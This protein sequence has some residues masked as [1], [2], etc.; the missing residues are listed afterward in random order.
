VN[1]AARHRPTRV[2]ARASLL[3]VTLSSAT[4]HAEGDTR[5]A[6]TTPPPAGDPSPAAPPPAASRAP[7][8]P[9]PA[10]PNTTW[11][12]DTLGD[13]LALV[14]VGS[15]AVGGAF[16]AAASA[17][18]TS[19]SSGKDAS[20][21]TERNKAKV[22]SIFGTTFICLGL[23]IFGTAQWRYFTVTSRGSDDPSAS[24]AVPSVGFGVER[25]GFSLSYA[26]TF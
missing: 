23:A 2:V 7:L 21:T 18:A 1:L 17:S 13:T 6:P 9:P 8:A 10:P 25:S 4:A 20:W 14:G 22:E 26:A 3:A 16:F 5:A 15:V 12:K 11:Y 19:A 24:R